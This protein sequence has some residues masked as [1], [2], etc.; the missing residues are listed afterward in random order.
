MSAS[1]SAIITNEEQR[2]W[3]G[4]FAFLIAESLFSRI[5][6]VPSVGSTLPASRAQRIQGATGVRPWCLQYSH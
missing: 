5:A 6:K 2:W 4:N 3:G 1:C